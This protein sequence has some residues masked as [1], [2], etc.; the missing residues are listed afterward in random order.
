MSLLRVSRLSKRFGGLLVTDDVTFDIAQG[1]VHALIGPNGAG[2]TTLMNQITG[3]LAPND[4]TIWLDGQN[5]TGL[6]AHERA[7]RG[8]A[9]SFQISSVFQSL[10]AESNVA[11]TIQAGQGHSF[12]FLRPVAKIEQL[13][14]AAT[15]VLK[16]AGF[17][18][19]ASATPAEM[20]YGER[21]QLE[22]AMAIAAKP[23]V[24]LL[25]EPMAG[26]SAEESA[27]MVALLR[28]LKGDYAI[29]LVEHD[30]DAVFSLADQ[31]TVLFGGKIIASGPPHVIRNDP[32]VRAAYLGEEA[33]PAVNDKQGRQPCHVSLGG[34]PPCE[35]AKE[36][37]LLKVEDVEAGYGASRVLFGAS[38]EVRRGE[39]IALLGR[40]GMGKS[41]LLKVIT[42]VIRPSAGIVNLDGEDITRLPIHQATARGIGVVPEGRRIFPSL[43]VEENLVATARLRP[44]ADDPWTLKRV[45]DL[46]PRLAERRSNFG[47]QLSGGEQQMLA[48]GRALMTNPK[49]LILD[50]ATEG[51]AP[52]I[53][54][55]IWRIIEEL[56]ALGQ[57]IIIVDKNIDAVSTLAD[58]LYV[59]EKGKV[60]WEGGAADFGGAKAEVYERVS[61]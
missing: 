44:A 54:A 36:P 17:G 33:S 52:L 58:R 6:A 12:R 29:L 1:S 23:K 4:G 35:P 42:G 24:L 19:V 51:L 14:E 60:V 30:M 31:I 21:R 48:I 26:L 59:L 43:T 32:A 56:K 2:K 9:R 57:A 38:L 7:R 61:V 27:D 10:S 15:A 40:N 37:P 34:R 13:R 41:T 49:L 20:S 18:G 11:F 39:V 16:R 28:E 25:D 3:D 5:V 46:F 8:L 53:R 47:N 22:L 55:E 45:H 50:E